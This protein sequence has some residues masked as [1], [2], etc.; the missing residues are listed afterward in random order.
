MKKNSLYDIEYFEKIKNEQGEKLKRL[1]NKR[2]IITVLLLIFILYLFL[3]ISRINTVNVVGNS[4]YSVAKIKEQAGVE[5]GQFN[6]LNP[7]FLINK[8]LSDTN[9]YQ[10]I[11]V[12]GSLFGDVS[13]KVKENKLLFYQI[14]KKKVVFS[15]SKNNSIMFDVNDTEY[16]QAQV[17]QLSSQVDGKIKA[18]VVDAL[19]KLD[20]SVLNEISEIIYTPKD[21]DD[22]FF[23]FI[24]NNK[25]EVYINANLKSLVNIGDKYHAVAANTKYACSSI[26]LIDNVVVEK[27]CA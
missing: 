10:D 22:H 16:I 8:R 24:M 12:D 21:Y 11:E 15:D 20:L 27:K 19:S 3:P 1:K 18:D 14:H 2:L 9:L 6:L 26:E 4:R 7:A 25:K 5:V 13:I 23:R 17:P